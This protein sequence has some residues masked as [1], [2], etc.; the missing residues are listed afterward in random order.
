MTILVRDT[1]FKNRLSRYLDL[2]ILIIVLIVFVIV[3]VISN[4]VRDREI[5]QRDN[6]S[7]TLTELYGQS[8][9][10]L[11]PRNEQLRSDIQSHLKLIRNGGQL[12]NP[13]GPS[14]TL[15]A[16]EHPQLIDAVIEVQQSLD[17]QD[18]EY[19]ETSYK[20]FSDLSANVSSQAMQ[21]LEQRQYLTAG[22]IIL[23]FIGVLGILFFRL[24]RA[25]DATQKISTENNHILSAMDDGLFLIDE[26]F[27]IGQQKSAAVQHIFGEN[28][29]VEGDFFDFLGRFVGREESQV[30]KE[31]LELLFAGRVKPK[32]MADLNPLKEVV[33]AAVQNS[34]LVTKKYLDFSFTKNEQDRQS[35]RILVTISDVTKEV[36]L[37]RELESTKEMQ[38]ERMA[39]LLGLLHIE[40]SELNSFLDHSDFVLNEINDILADENA[41]H[42]ATLDK[43]TNIYQ[44]AHQLKGE[45]GALGVDL[46]ESSIHR[47]EESIEDVKKIPYLDGRNILPLTVQLKDMI[48]EIDL[49]RSLVPQMNLI[50]AAHFPGT[51]AEGVEADEPTKTAVA[52]LVIDETDSKDSS[53]KI[54]KR[55]STLAQRA[56]K[57]Q[58][59]EVQLDCSS[60]DLFGDNKELQD[61]VYS[62]S[63]Q[64]VRNSIV[65]GIELPEQRQRFG[66]SRPGHVSVL[67]SELEDGSVQLV[68]RDDGAGLQ[69]N[70]IRQHAAAQ[71]LI[72]KTEAMSLGSKGLLQYIFMP[73]FSSSDGVGVDAGRGVGLDI[74]KSQVK[75][76]SGTIAVKS[77][78]NKYC[79]FTIVVPPA[80]APINS[81]S[82]RGE[83]VL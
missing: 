71:G 5:L 46:F 51:V 61:A 43:L 70:K 29:Q 32:L 63:V 79:Q 60:F 16:S 77:A 17:R 78:D 47:F 4:G 18:F 54:R 9:Q 35:K 57:R 74:V 52:E 14:W 15:P 55:L 1:M 41:N 76:Y 83:L 27:Q 75:K 65:H 39:M 50:A 20:N 37:R 11:G 31:Y 53:L 68:V 62:I 58:G 7:A 33:T 49:V 80:K 59:K 40:N 2:I 44:L 82:D 36:L 3:V 69:F 30:S 8:L 48:S 28:T 72:D 66:K 12:A 10:S 64:L 42:R 21:S 13:Y 25:D 45:A 38:K 6:Y 26:E 81:G 24:G 19:F 73:G 22:I 34:G 23:G 67:L 56:A